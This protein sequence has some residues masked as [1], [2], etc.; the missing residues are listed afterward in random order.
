MGKIDEQCQAFRGEI[1]EICSHQNFSDLI[2]VP[3]QRQVADLGFHQI[4]VLPQKDREA[5]VI[6]V[7]TADFLLESLDVAAGMWSVVGLDA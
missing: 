4:E 3:R 2:E 7:M 6:R 1:A 5:K